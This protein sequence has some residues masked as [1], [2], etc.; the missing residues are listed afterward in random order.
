[1]RERCRSCRRSTRAQQLSAV[2]LRQARATSRPTRRG[3]R[4]RAR[5]RRREILL[6]DIPSMTMTRELPSLAA[7][8]ALGHELALLAAPGS[9]IL[10][11]GELGAGKTTLAR[12]IIRSLS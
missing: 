7:T 1:M 5:W 6:V 12:A 9:A 3:S 8:E 2:S 4:C 11:A 10:L